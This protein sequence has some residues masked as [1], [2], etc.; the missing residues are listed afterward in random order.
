MTQYFENLQQSFLNLT[1]SDLNEIQEQQLLFQLSSKK[2]SELID[3]TIDDI[4]HQIKDKENLF[5][6]HQIQSDKL[7][8]QLNKETQF[9]LNQIYTYQFY[10]VYLIFIF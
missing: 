9:L 4:N 7:F 2:S 1:K 5:K 6:Q 8:N 10:F 3:S